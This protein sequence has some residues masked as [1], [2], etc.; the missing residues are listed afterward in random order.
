MPK[1]KGRCGGLALLTSAAALLLVGQAS[2]AGYA[3]VAAL[4]VALRAAGAYSG[5]VDGLRGP[6]TSD[7]LL[8]FQERAGL[9]P[10]GIPGPLTRRALGDLGTPELGS[11]SLSFG[12]RGWDVAELQFRLAWH[13]FP[14]GPFDGAF[15]PALEAAVRRFQRFAHLPAIGIAGPRTIAALGRA[16]PTSP[17]DLSAPVAGRLGDG[18]GPRGERLPCRARLRRSGRRAVIAARAA[19]S[20]GPLPWEASA[21]PSSFDTGQGVRTLYAHLSMIDVG[22]LDR[23]STGTRLGL[24]GSTGRST[25]PHLHFEVR[26]RA[27]GPARRPRPR[28]TDTLC[29]CIHSREASR[30]ACRGGRRGRASARGAP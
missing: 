9:V 19:A 28:S 26:V 23:V 14:S 25:G 15:G 18:F 6:R 11:R 20:C 7:A 22:L 13:G 8:A 17:L 4:Q 3:D 29:Q 24:V 21:T 10:D 2:A 30:A 1:D 16:R 27:R 12:T 5:D